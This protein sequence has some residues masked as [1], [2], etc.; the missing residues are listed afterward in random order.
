MNAIGDACKLTMKRFVASPIAFISHER[1]Q[2][3][4]KFLNISSKSMTGMSRYKG[5]SLTS[6]RLYISV[7]KFTILNK[8][9]PRFY[10]NVLLYIYS[11]GGHSFTLYRRVVFLLLTPALLFSM[12]KHVLGDIIMST[13]V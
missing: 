11:P 5:N 6:L 9:R 4:I 3:V 10:G 13:R 7:P 2:V 8:Y 12:V 1:K